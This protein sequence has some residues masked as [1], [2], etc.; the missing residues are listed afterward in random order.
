M[1][2]DGGTGYEWIEDLIIGRLL[3]PRVA[4]DL[5][6]AE[7]EVVAAHIRSEILF[8][9]E[10]HKMLQVKANDVLKELRG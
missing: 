9:P 10:I 7:L 6:A 8:T 4:A 2:G 1:S 5:S 3:D